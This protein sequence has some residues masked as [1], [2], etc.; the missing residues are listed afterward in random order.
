MARGRRSYS[1]RLEI[2]Y[3][4]HKLAYQDADDTWHCFA[5]SFESQS[6]RRVRAMI[7]AHGADIRRIDKFTALRLD[8]HGDGFKPVVV[9]MIVDDKECW[10]HQDGQ[11]RK[12]EFQDLV[13]D[14]PAARK[15]LKEFEEAS[16]AAEAAAN[17]AERKKKAVPR[18]SRRMLIEAKVSKAD[19]ES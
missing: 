17:V 16:E 7:D 18:L 13:P 10:I 9:T 1:D 8:R 15:K 5:L 3:K 11:R 2:D 14:T 12:A 4:G 6:L 19:A